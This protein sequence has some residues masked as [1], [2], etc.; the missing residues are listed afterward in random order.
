[1]SFIHP[2]PATTPAA[3][4]TERGLLDSARAPLGGEAAGRPAAS[5]TAGWL[6]RHALLLAVLWIT[7]AGVVAT[8]LS[9]ARPWVGVQLGVV[10]D[11]VEVLAVHDRSPAQDAGLRPG[12][13]LLAVTSL[14]DDASITLEPADLVENPDQLP[15]YAAWA[16]FYERQ[17]LLARLWGE[18]LVRLQLQAP[19]AAPVGIELAPAKERPF[20]ALSN[21]FW[22]LFLVQAVSLLAAAWVLVVYPTQAATV[23]S[24]LAALMLSVLLSCAAVFSGREL[25]LPAGLFH[26]LLFINHAASIGAL[27]FLAGLL[28][29]FPVRLPGAGWHKAAVAGVFGLWALANALWWLPSPNWASRGMLLA[30]VGLV[31]LQMARQWR[32]SAAHTP[33]RTLLRTL[34]LPWG[35]ALAALLGLQEGVL[36]FGGTPPVAQAWLFGLIFATSVGTAL[37]LRGSR[38]FDLDDRAMQALLSLGAGIGTLVCY[39]LIQATE[40]LN[41]DLAMLVAVLL[42]GLT[43]VP[44][45]SGVWGRSI[46]RR[47]P[48]PRE[49]TSG[50]LA[51]GLAPP[52]ERLQHWAN[53]LTQTLQVRQLGH[54][55]PPA[56][57]RSALEPTVSANGQVLWVPPVAE[58][59]GFTLWAR[60][61][62]GRLFSRG[63]RRLAQRLSE[64]VAQTIQAHDAYVRGASD[65]RERIADDLHDDLGAKLLSLVHASGQTDPAVSS[66]AREA[67][68]EMRLSVRN[69]KAQPLPV[70]DVLADWRAETVSRLTGAGIEVDWDA[71]L[72]DGMVLMPVRAGAQLTR[73]LREAV[74][75]VIRHS[76]AGHCRV[77]LQVTEGDLQ[78]EVEDNGRGLDTVALARSAGHGLPNIERRV[79]RLG[80]THRFTTGSLGGTLLLVR[81]PLEPL[82]P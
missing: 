72:P 3:L 74:S 37:G 63:D 78:L 60:D 8:A 36:M 50:I 2:P 27:L 41:D 6:R 75:N 67:L 82:R 51:L 7:L 79:R 65:E 15:S 16:R 56:E 30:G 46:L 17:D 14:L 39:R 53:L 19:E 52:G 22:F 28:T 45:S 33:E 9:M 4:D 23:C 13:R 64:L 35:L 68:E 43:Y 49:L 61:R 1:M 42:F 26:T 81:V 62:G 69:L 24:S 47:G 66:Q 10:G 11:Q 18:P 5:R 31:F 40:W 48:T 59:P 73:V 55:P 29:N 44:L 58:L 25:A 80:G 20:R 12:M 32:A 21:V 57:L 34:A 71:T 38:A 54:E 76:G 70:A 77:R